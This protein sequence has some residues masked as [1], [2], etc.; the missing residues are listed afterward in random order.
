MTCSSQRQNRT[1]NDDC[2]AKW[3]FHINFKTPLCVPRSYNIFTMHFALILSLNDQC[4]IAEFYMVWKRKVKIRQVSHVHWTCG[5]LKISKETWNFRAIHFKI[6]YAWMFFIPVINILVILYSVL[7]R[8][9]KFWF[10]FLCINFPT[11]SKD[12]E[13]QRTEPNEVIVNP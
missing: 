12:T 13:T 4:H 7:V 1:S 6:I 2:F 8:V 3:D 9:F 11:I 5:L 10:L